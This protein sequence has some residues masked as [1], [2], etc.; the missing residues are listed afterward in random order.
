MSR[1][2]ALAGVLLEL[3][4][5]GEGR[6]LLFLHPGEGLEPCREWLDLLARRC[7]RGGATLL[8]LRG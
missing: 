2:I 3:E 1:T 5:R 6:P 7:I 8:C 4:E